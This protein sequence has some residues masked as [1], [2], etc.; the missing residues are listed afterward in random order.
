MV[1]PNEK[2]NFTKKILDDLD[3]P[4]EGKRY[5]YKDERERGLIVRVTA[6]GQKTFQLY[7]KHQGR[8]VRVTLGVYPDMSIENA[9]KEA[10]KAKGALAAGEN[11]NVEKNKLRQELTLK[12]FFDLYLERYSKLEKKSWEYDVREVNKFLAHWFNRRLSDIGKHEIQQLHLKLREKNGLYQA[13]RMLE[14]LRAMYNKA[15][16]WGLDGEN[17]TQGIKKYKEKSRDR[18]ILPMEM[19]LFMKAVEMEENQTAK[20]YFLIALFT[21]ARKTNVLQMRWEQIDWHNKTWRIPDT[22]NGEPLVIPLTNEAEKILEKRLKLVHGSPWVFPSDTSKE[23]YYNDPKKAWNRVRQR[24]TIMLWQQTELF[25]ELIE[26]VDTHIKSQNN[27]VYST[28]KLFN[29][30]EKKAEAR[31]LEL[32]TGLMDIRLHDIRR[33]FG[34]YQ[35]ITGSSLQIIGKSLGHKSQQSTE[36]YSRLHNDPVKASMEK[37]T[38]AMLAFMGEEVGN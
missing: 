14:R 33:T 30:I 16:E 31:D 36:V 22:K 5:I 2:V 7:K 9:R 1:A 26:E 24:A 21:G 35:A 11:P 28:L 18:Y 23:G 4:P 15:I 8:P 12:E 13:N 3:L 34:S 38:N 32:P 27:Y 25:A 17:P 10:L 19:P 20:D 6:A 37:A 29:A